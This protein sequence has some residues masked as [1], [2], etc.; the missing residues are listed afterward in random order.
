MTPT[1]MANKWRVEAATAAA[2]F[3]SRW[4]LIGLRRH[5]HDL[6]VALY[7]QKELFHEACAI[8]DLGEIRDHGAALV[9]GYAAATQAME[10]AQIPDDSYLLGTCPTTGYRIAIGINKASIRRVIELYGQEVIWFSPDEVAT[11][12]ASSEAFLKV[13]ALKKKFP[14]AEVVERY[15]GEGS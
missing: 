6:A 13:G 8:G 4:T 2:A 7:E 3:E 1:Q 11:L 15:V 10:A 14:G 9:R 12:A 5:D